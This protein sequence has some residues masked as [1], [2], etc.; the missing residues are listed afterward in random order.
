M[1][2]NGRGFQIF[3]ILIAMFLIFIL[4]K[5]QPNQVKGIMG[6]ASTYLSSPQLS[7]SGLTTMLWVEKI[8]VNVGQM[9]AKDQPIITLKSIDLEQQIKRT[10]QNILLYEIDQQR[11]VLLQTLYQLELAWKIDTDVLALK[12]QKKEI[13]LSLSSEMAK[14]SHLGGSLDRLKNAVQSGLM[15][16][17]QL[18]EVGAEMAVLEKRIPVLKSKQAQ[19]KIKE[20][21]E[22]QKISQDLTQKELSYLSGLI[23]KEKEFLQSLIQQQDNLKI[24]AFQDLKIQQILI[25]EGQSI[26]QNTQ[27]FE[28]SVFPN[29][30]RLWVH[31]RTSKEDLARFHIG[32]SI[33]IFNHLGESVVAKI[34]Q[35]SS[36]LQVM[37]YPL[38]IEAQKPELGYFLQVD[39][40]QI[41]H[42][43]L[44]GQVLTAILERQ[45]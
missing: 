6:N 29:L 42:P 19:I 2:I 43:F 31:S 10:E 3:S 4:G 44:L 24:K 9:L 18:I 40:S 25:H 23:Q 38:S 22:L 21:T 36:V 33:R 7:N 39:L 32:Q 16:Q 27:M 41:E 37:P 20:P 45:E 30:A 17:D 1:K 28:L 26:P 5:T 34:Q 11:Q 35:N 8:H 14:L 15:A 13:D 12:N